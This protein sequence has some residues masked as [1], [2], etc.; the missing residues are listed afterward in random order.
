M[1]S[2]VIYICAIS[3]ALAS[4]V[5]GVTAYRFCIDLWVQSTLRQVAANCQIR[6]LCALCQN[7]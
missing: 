7:G 2:N 6:R 1:Y 3:L 5:H 4:N